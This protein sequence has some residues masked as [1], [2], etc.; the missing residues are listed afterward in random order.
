MELRGAVGQVRW[1]YHTAAAL[2]ACVIT[3]AEDKTHYHAVA[4]VVTAN[5]F[6]LEHSVPLV[7]VLE[8]AGGHTWRWPIESCGVHDDDEHGQVFRAY[9]GPALS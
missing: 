3:R 8:L 5:P 1:V 6:M 9:L 2:E 7:F 4:R